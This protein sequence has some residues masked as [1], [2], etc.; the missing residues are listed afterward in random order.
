M[1]FTACSYVT[2][3]GRLDPAMRKTLRSVV[4][5]EP[6]SMR[7]LC[8]RIASAVRCW[9]GLCL[10]TTQTPSVTPQES[11]G[12]PFNHHRRRSCEGRSETTLITAN[13]RRDE[14]GEGQQR[15]DEGARAA[16]RDEQRI[17]IKYIIA[18]NRGSA[19]SCTHW[20]GFEAEERRER[21][22]RH[23]ARPAIRDRRAI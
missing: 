17:R 22:Y 3:L 9:P 12:T 4:A 19:V 6:Q 15:E 14:L 5:R 13:A 10:R 1:S 18:W 7:L 23:Q 21:T 11:T 16:Q 8:K 2:A 20:G